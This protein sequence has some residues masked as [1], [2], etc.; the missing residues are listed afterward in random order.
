MQAAMGQRPTPAQPNAKP[1]Y[2]FQQLEE[3]RKREQD[4][5]KYRDLMRK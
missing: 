1:N 3:Q 2:H 4:A 5:Q